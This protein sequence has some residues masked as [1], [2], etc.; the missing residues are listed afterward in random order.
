MARF[1]MDWCN[2]QHC[3]TMSASVSS[4]LTIDWQ[5]HLRHFSHTSSPLSPSPLHA[6][7]S[8]CFTMLAVQAWLCPYC[9]SPAARPIKKHLERAGRSLR[10]G[11]K[12]LRCWSWLGPPEDCCFA[13]AWAIIVAEVWRLPR[14]CCCGSESGYGATW[15]WN[16]RQSLW[17]SWLDGGV[18]PS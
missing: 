8:M 15:S 16:H 9:Y 5:R 17:N 6:P 13:W 18:S 12:R 10:T 11:L 14:E 3:A 7:A 1:A 4:T 2:S